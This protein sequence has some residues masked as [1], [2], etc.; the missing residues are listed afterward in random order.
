MTKGYCLLH[1]LLIFFLIFKIFYI[2]FL[3]QFSFWIFEYYVRNE[4]QLN[5]NLQISYITYCCFLWIKKKHHLTT[6]PRSNPSPEPHQRK[7]NDRGAAISSISNFII[8]KKPKQYCIEV[9]CFQLI[10]NPKE[11]ALRF[12]R[13][14]SICLYIYNICFPG[15]SDGK[16][17]AC[18]VGDLGSI[19]GSGRSPGEGNGN[20]L[21]YPCLEN[22]MDRGAW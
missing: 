13:T 1:V 6:L 22:P 3:K 8:W 12:I 20:P 9:S 11:Q 21:Q 15:G 7:I 18:N 10:L 4:V 19:P 2:F 16:M 17:S 14:Y 5:I